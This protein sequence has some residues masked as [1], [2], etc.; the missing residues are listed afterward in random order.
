MDMEQFLLVEIGQGLKR[1]Y[2]KLLTWS[3]AFAVLAAVLSFVVL[4]PDY[5]SRATF[6]VSRPASY[7]SGDQPVEY[8]NDIQMYQQ[9][10]RT[11]A[12]ILKSE[13][14]LNQVKENLGLDLI[15]QELADKM[16]VRI[17]NNSNLVSLTVIDEDAEQAAAIANETTRVFQTVVQETMEE[18]NVTIFD[19]ARPADESLGSGVVRNTIMGAMF[20]FLVALLVAIFKEFTYPSVRSAQ[21][22]SRSFSVPVIGTIPKY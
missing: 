11:Y 1:H 5:K 13:T 20:G 15:T 18:D 7:E 21:D 4:K 19:E 22:F 3:L 16:T 9:L 12:E 10:V 14:V 8:N 2:K 17:E 6:I